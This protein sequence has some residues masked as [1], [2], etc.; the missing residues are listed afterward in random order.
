MSNRLQNKRSLIIGG[1]SGIGLATARRF[2]YEGASVVVAD[3]DRGYAGDLNFIPCDARDA[4]QVDSLLAQT[5]QHLGGLDILFHVAGISGRK[6][7]DG[8]LHECTD[9]GWD[10]TLDANLKSVF[11]TNRA[12]IRQFLAQ[13]TG[14]VILNMA[15]VLA[16]SPA[17]T[18]FDT[19][20]YTASKGGVI[21]LSQYAA[22]RYAKNRIRVNVLAPGLIDTPMATRAV[23][24]PAIR[25]YLN[26][27]QPLGPG[28]GTP[29]DCATA[30]LYLCS[31]EARFVTGVVL[32]VDG[33]W[34]VSEG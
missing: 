22:A 21:A 10:A 13:G 14:G 20:A 27:K 2:A 4:S 28:P 15:S 29:D 11:L 23:N 25:T 6:H 26:A 30:A 12:A 24:D 7:G 16:I 18:F 8:A 31:D 33:G 32:P 1:T 3:L 17:P 19:A 34:C 5:I 9:G